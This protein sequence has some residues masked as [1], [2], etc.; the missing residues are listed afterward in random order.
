MDNQPSQKLAEFVARLRFEDIPAPVVRRAE[1]LFLDWLG[2]AL[3]GRSSRA[4]QVIE[5]FAR[6]MGPADGEAEVLI[7]RR[8][9]S[10]LFAAMVNAADSHVVEQDDLHNGSV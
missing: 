1:D 7:S 2:S 3:A 9:T 10:P 5:G 4:V 6:Q 8:M